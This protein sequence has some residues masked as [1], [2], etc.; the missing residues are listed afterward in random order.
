[1][2]NRWLSGWAGT[3][4]LYLALYPRYGVWQVSDGGQLV[5]NY[6]PSRK[7]KGTAVQTCDAS[8]KLMRTSHD[9]KKN[10]TKQTK[11]KSALI[12]TE[13]VGTF[14]FFF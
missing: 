5:A 12:D 14:N 4:A 2:S 9:K 6:S 11:K 8:D 10:K 1:M 3:A 13:T 7:K